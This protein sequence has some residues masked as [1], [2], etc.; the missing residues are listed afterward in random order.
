MQCDMCGSGAPLFRT[1]IEDTEMVVCSSCSSFGK[2]LGEIKTGLKDK[3][4]KKAV[5][6][7]AEAGHLP[8]E[9]PKENGVQE[10]IVDNYPDIIRGKREQL[11]MTQKEFAMFVA[12]KESIIRKIETGT[13][14]PG[15]RMARK[16]EKLLKVRL[17]EEY[18]E[19]G[20]SANADKGAEP[21]TIGDLVAIKTR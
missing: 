5:L 8:K 2:V 14:E 15:I 3:P 9:N 17:I 19:A 20:N 21:V 18:K 7:Q 16:F 10:I 13:F 1:V 4:P 6:K 12:E 11:G